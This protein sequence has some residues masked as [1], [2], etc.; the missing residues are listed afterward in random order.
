M[1]TLNFWGSTNHENC[2]RQRWCSKIVGKWNRKSEIRPACEV[3]KDSISINLPAGFLRSFSAVL[4][5]INCLVLPKPLRTI[6]R[7]GSSRS[8]HQPGRLHRQWRCVFFRLSSGA[9]TSKPTEF[10][11]KPVGS[12]S[13]SSKPS[14][15]Q[16]STVTWAWPRPPAPWLGMDTAGLCWSLTIQKNGESG[17]K[18]TYRPRPFLF[19]Q[20]PYQHH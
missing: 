7:S 1:E 15:S 10:H 11:P 5:F 4:R 13:C 3:A 20:S 6:S 2:P 16:K 19:F 9:T 14:M 12:R 18:P 8:N 17:A